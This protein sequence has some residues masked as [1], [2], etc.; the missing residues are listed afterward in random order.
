MYECVCVIGRVRLAA[1]NALMLKI[2]QSMIWA[3]GM[4]WLEWHTK[5]SQKR[6]KENTKY[7]K[8]D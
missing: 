2:Y 5:S 1:E 7:V 3:A 6:Q 8:D 4:R